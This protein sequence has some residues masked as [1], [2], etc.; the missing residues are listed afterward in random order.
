MSK[1]GYIFKDSS[2]LANAVYNY[3]ELYS[4]HSV[5]SLSDGF[6][7]AESF[8]LEKYGNPETWDIIN[9]TNLDNLFYDSYEPIDFSIYD[10][11]NWNT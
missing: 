1:D 10:I 6:I 7:K 11:S 2:E 4:Q 9:V 5:H 8:I 3:Y